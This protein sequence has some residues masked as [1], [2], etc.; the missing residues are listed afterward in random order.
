M[1]SSSMLD[2]TMRKIHIFH[3]CHV[4]G[5]KTSITFHQETCH[6]TCFAFML[7]ALKKATAKPYFLHYDI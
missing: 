1:R 4:K 2:E 6:Q 7:L 5:H 3:L